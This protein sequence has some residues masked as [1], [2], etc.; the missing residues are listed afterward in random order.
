MLRPGGHNWVLN[1]LP[2]VHHE[3]DGELRR[4]TEMNAVTPVGSR[5]MC[6]VE[7]TSG[8][9]VCDMA[10]NPKLRYV[11]LLLL[12]PRT[13]HRSSDWPDMHYCRNLAAA[14]L[15]VVRF[16]SV[17]PRCFYGGPGT[18]TCE[19]SSFAFNVTTWTLVLRME[20]PMAWFKAR[21]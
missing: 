18:T 14:G 11:P 19:R 6:W 3:G 8:F 5:F 2:I 13:R 21:L 16:V 7:Y 9:L 20:E 1:R 4:W 17:A 10:E 12:A 15:G